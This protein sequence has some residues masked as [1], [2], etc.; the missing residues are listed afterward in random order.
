[1]SQATGGCLF[2]T[3]LGVVLTPLAFNA[4]LAL[5]GGYPVAYAL[6][7]VPALAVGARLLARR[8]R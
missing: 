6:F 2:Y 1:V 7:G 5:G 8:P 3:F 4:V